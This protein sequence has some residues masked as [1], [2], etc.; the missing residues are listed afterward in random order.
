MGDG[1]RPY[2]GE[3]KNHLAPPYSH[4]MPRHSSLLL[5]AG[6]TTM[7]NGYFESFNHKLRDEQL[8]REVFSTLLEVKA[9]TESIGNLQLHQ[10]AQFTRLQAAGARDFPTQRRCSQPAGLT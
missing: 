5:A 10:A 3:A 2:P 7:E 6:R 1:G 4:C 8:G 9:L